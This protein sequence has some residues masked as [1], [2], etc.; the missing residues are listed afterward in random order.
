MYICPSCG[1]P[2]TLEKRAHVCVSGIRTIYHPAKDKDG[3]KQ[4]L[5]PGYM[6]SFGSRQ[7]RARLTDLN[8]FGG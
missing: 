6:K 3:S 4:A 7:K 5:V 1:K 8:P 2:I